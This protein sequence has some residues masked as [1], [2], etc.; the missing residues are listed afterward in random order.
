MFFKINNITKKK[1]RLNKF[2]NKKKILKETCKNI[3]NI[4]NLIERID[5][6]FPFLKNNKKLNKN[7]NF[8][9]VIHPYCSEK[10]KLILN[11]DKTNRPI[12]KLE[13]LKN[14]KKKYNYNYFYDNSIIHEDKKN[15]ISPKMNVELF[16]NYINNYNINTNKFIVTHSNFLTLFM[17]YIYN[18]LNNSNSNIVFDNLDILQLILLPNKNTRDNIIA[19]I[20]RRFKN[21]YKENIIYINTNKYDKNINLKKIYVSNKKHINI[22]LIRHCI[23]CHNLLD[24]TFT[25]IIKYLNPK[26]N[27]EAFFEWA[28]CIKKTQ[29]ELNKKYKPLHKLLK[30]FSKHNS[31][32]KK[33]YGYEYGSSIVFRSILTILLIFNTLFFNKH[34]KSRKHNK[35][36]KR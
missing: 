35:S 20:I 3:K 14:I 2:K 5:N 12:I 24:N 27:N 8:K 23:G 4:D 16:Y 6:I 10:P 13:L 1:Y 18:I 7:V 17:N 22:F 15:I 28:M 31:T 19:I 33:Y 21:N 32:K 29:Q 9:Y 36:I 30:D 11:M 25:K 26:Q 34:R